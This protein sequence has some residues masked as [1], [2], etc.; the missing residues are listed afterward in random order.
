MVT[1]VTWD[2]LFS[3]PLFLIFTKGA[4]ISEGYSIWLFLLQVILMQLLIIV[5]KSVQFITSRLQCVL[6]C[7]LTNEIIMCIIII[8]FFSKTAFPDCWMS[9]K[10][11]FSC[12][13]ERKKLIILTEYTIAEKP[14]GK[15]LTIWSSEFVESFYV[16]LCHAQAFS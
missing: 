3:Q 9:Y 10:S 8:F 6:G 16:F 15:L 2:D 13:C 4:K 7:T 11:L 14:I 1:Y 12:L 5:E